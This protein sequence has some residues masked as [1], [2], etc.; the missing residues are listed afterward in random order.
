MSSKENSYQREEVLPLEEQLDHAIFIAAKWHY[1]Q[2]DKQGVNYILH[3]LAVMMWAESIEEKIVAVLHDIVEDTD[4]E[5]DDLRREG[6]SENLVLAIEAMTKKEEEDYDAYIKRIHENSLAVKVKL[7][8]LRHNLRKG[9]PEELR[10]KYERALL[11]LE[12]ERQ[13]G[14]EC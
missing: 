6:F 1:G 10:E 8:D 11:F 3:P 7:L 5:F 14:V 12:R 2:K 4:L 13:T 9:C